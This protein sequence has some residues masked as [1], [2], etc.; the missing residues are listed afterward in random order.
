MDHPQER[1]LELLMP[2][3]HLE[4]FLQLDEERLDPVPLTPL[5]ADRWHGVGRLGTGRGHRLGPDLGARP[6]LRRR[7]NRST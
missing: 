3:G 4:E 2:G 1:L 7:W 6:P 5:R